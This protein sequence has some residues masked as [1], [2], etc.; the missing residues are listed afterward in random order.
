MEAIGL[1]EL[2]FQIKQELLAPNP[3]QRAKDPYP[4]FFIDK[5]DLEIAVKVSRTSNAG[6]KLTVMDFAEASSGKSMAHE[7]GH[8]VRV[9]LT[10]LLSRDELVAEALKD[11]RV[12]EIIA[13]RSP[14][15]VIKGGDG[16]LGEPE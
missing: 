1:Q 7:R 16:P 2:I 9:S 6:I 10:P 5:I 11:P 12:R 13:K 3:A 15:A 4:L 14:H 8:V